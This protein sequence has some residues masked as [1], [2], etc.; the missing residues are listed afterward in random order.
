[1]QTWRQVARDITHVATGRTITW[2]SSAASVPMVQY[3]TSNSK[4]VGGGTWWIVSLQTVSTS[5]RQI[6]GS[7]VRYLSAM[8]DSH[9][10]ETLVLQ[11]K[12]RKRLSMLFLFLYLQL[13]LLTLYHRELQG[14]KIFKGFNRTELKMHRGFN[15]SVLDQRLKMLEGFNKQILDQGIETLKGFNKPVLD[16][17]LKILEGFSKM[18]LNLEG[19]KTIQDP[20]IIK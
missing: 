20:K 16:Q 2:S 12:Y 6:S 14:L 5:H 13:C 15:K 9:P 11:L 8:E 19:H 3:L 18:I 1:M 17:E 4:P 10:Q 7:L